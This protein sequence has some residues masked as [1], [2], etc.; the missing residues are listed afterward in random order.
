[1]QR[2]WEGVM[3]QMFAAEAEA[4]NEISSDLDGQRPP[5]HVGTV[6]CKGT[7][8]GKQVR[9]EEAA[10]NGNC[11][12]VACLDGQRRK[13]RLSRLSVPTGSVVGER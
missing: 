8:L 7:L 13:A 11:K 5:S 12:N 3:G 10:G 4:W 6:E 9:T 1:V 2:S